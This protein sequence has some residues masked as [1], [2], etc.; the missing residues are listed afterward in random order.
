MPD[1]NPEI[2]VNQ[3]FSE[4]VVVHKNLSPEILV[5]DVA[6]LKNI[7]RDYDD[8][9]KKSGDWISVLALVISLILANCTSSFTSFWGLTPDTWKAIFIICTILSIVWLVAIVFRLCIT[10][11]LRNIDHLIKTI[12]EESKPGNKKD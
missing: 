3:E 9:V 4:R 1:N 11:K 10:I 8:A 7:I 5:I 6:K 12:T 2:N